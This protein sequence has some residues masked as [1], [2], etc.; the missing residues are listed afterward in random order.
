MAIEEVPFIPLGQSF[1]PTAFRTTLSGFAMSPYPVF[2][3]VKKA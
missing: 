1:A 3:G 2:W